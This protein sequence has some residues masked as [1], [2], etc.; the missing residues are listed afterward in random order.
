MKRRDY[1][2]GFVHTVAEIIGT[3]IAVYHERV[4]QF[5]HINM[6]CIYVAQFTQFL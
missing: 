3:L 4:V 5:F 2:L 1:S 6:M